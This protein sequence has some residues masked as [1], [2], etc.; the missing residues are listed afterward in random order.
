LLLTRKTFIEEIENLIVCFFIVI[1]AVVFVEVLNYD[2]SYTMKTSAQRGAAIYKQ[3]RNGANWPP[4]PAAFTAEATKHTIKKMKLTNGCVVETIR[5]DKVGSTSIPAGTMSGY[6][7]AFFDPK[8]V[9]EFVTQVVALKKS[10]TDP[11]VASAAIGCDGDSAHI[12][13]IYGKISDNVEL[14]WSVLLRIVL[15]GCTT[16]TFRITI[17]S[18]T[19]ITPLLY[20]KHKCEHKSCHCFDNLNERQLLDKVLA[21]LKIQ[22]KLF[23][24]NSETGATGAPLDAGVTLTE[25]KHTEKSYPV[26]VLIGLK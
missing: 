2:E 22:P 7:R 1:I 23:S 17:D 9:G 24:V 3:K 4:K 21:K 8:G 13:D 14:L 18:E 25:P 12:F 10:P 5:R 6:S 16:V 26:E 15:K 20:E 11:I 19:D